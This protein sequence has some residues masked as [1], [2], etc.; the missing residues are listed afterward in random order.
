MREHDEHLRREAAPWAVGWAGELHVAR[1]LSGLLARDNRWRILH[2]VPVGAS[3]SDIDHVLIGPGGFFTLNAKHHRNASIWV[4]GGTFMVNGTRHPYVRNA[5]HEAQ[6][7][8]RVLST[9]C[10]FGVHTQAVIV[11]VNARSITIRA[12][13]EVAVISHVALVNWL[14]RFPDV[15]PMPV[16][17]RVFA[18]A[19]RPSTWR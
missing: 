11:P 7:A 15:V 4:A 18:A 19:R 2:S 16:V 8:S 17:E 10:G 14:Q 3:G 6:R 5:R 13:P 12:A 9:A 1:E